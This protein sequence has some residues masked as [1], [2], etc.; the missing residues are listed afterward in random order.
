MNVKC[1]SYVKARFVGVLFSGSNNP[2]KEV[3][4]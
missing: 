4:G 2:C 1:V 3:G